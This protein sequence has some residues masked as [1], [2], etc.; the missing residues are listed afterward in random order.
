MIKA[1]YIYLAIGYDASKSH[2]K[3]SLLYPLLR[4]QFYIGVRTG[5]LPD[6]SYETSSRNKQWNYIAKVPLAI[7]SLRQEANES[8]IFV[9]KYFKERGLW[10][11]LANKAIVKPIEPQWGNQHRSGKKASAE[12]IAKQ[13]ANSKPMPIGQREAQSKAWGGANNPNAGQNAR[14]GNEHPM[15]GKTHSEYSKLIGSYNKRIKYQNKHGCCLLHSKEPF[16]ALEAYLQ[17]V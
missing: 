12:N 9:L 2:N 14:K 5:L 8:E 11:M 13:K 7:Y 15:F 10:N 4:M 6:N 17:Y 3:L 1:H 16:L